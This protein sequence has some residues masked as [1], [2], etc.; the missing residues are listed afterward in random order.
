MK[1][2]LVCGGRDWSRDRYQFLH[3]VLNKKIPKGSLLIVGE[4]I[5]VDTQA[6]IWAN[7][8][9]IDVSLFIAN[10]AEFGKRAGPLRNKDMLDKGKPDMVIAFPGG[11]GTK[12]MI[13]QATRACVPVLRVT[14]EDYLE[15]RKTHPFIV[16]LSGS[17][18]L[19]YRSR[20][21]AA[22]RAK[23]QSQEDIKF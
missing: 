5:G 18:E 4:A 12:N 23:K 22:L 11:K 1:K 21:E 9:G 10:W 8:G 14:E 3:H 6:A 7:R 17:D 20:V 13:M 16:P 2:I 15:Y 19:S